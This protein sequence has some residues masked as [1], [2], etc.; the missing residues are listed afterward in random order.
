MKKLPLT[1]IFLL[2]GFLTMNAQSSNGNSIPEGF[3]AGSIVMPDNT[4]LTGYVRNNMKK[5][6]EVIFLSPD[7]KKIKYTA[8]QVS[9]ISIDNNHY[10]VANNAFYKVVTDGA[11]IKLLRKASNASGIQ[12]NGSEPIV[13]DAGEG[14]YDDYFIQTVSTKKLQLV[15]KKDFQKVFTSACSDC[16]TLTDDLK[17]NKLGF[18]EIEQAVALYNACEK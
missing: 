12:Y 15:R 14:S 10:I 6:G 8:T 3:N 13:L 17:A 18:A 11:K 7:G 2:S 9:S 16:T 4:T 1:A 5:N